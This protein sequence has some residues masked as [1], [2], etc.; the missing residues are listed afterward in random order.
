M[1]NLLGENLNKTMEKIWRICVGPDIKNGKCT[2]VPNG[3]HKMDDCVDLK[4]YNGIRNWRCPKC[5]EI[6]RQK[7]REKN[8]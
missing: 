3:F 2:E 6:H 5:F 4:P 1:E 7:V 8:S